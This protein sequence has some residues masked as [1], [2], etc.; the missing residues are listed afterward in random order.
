MAQQA[1]RVTL[2]DDWAAQYDTAVAAGGQD[3]PFV[4]YGEVL[5]TAVRTAGA[6]PSL[7]VLELGI[8]T[9]KE[10]SSTAAT[11]S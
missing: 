8:G 11:P 2:F 9:L 6:R 5:D 4:G 1:N 3:F 10:T 7:R